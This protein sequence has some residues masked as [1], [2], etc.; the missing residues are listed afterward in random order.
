MG[1]HAQGRIEYD[2]EVDAAYLYLTDARL[3][4]GRESIEL[5][6]PPDS[7]A[8]VVMDWKDGKIT[9]LEVL[10]ASALLHPDL[11]AQAMPPGDDPDLPAGSQR[12]RPDD[13]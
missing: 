2:P 3:T 5:E 9:G 6:T 1:H 10:E 12:G 4:P 7:P 11:L 8:T 13:R